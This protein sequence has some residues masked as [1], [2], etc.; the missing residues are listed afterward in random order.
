MVNVCDLSMILL[1]Q[2]YLLFASECLVGDV[3]R[4]EASH[5]VIV[6][7]HP[8]GRCSTRDIS[9]ANVRVV[10]S[11]VRDAHVDNYTVQLV[12][13]VAV[14][15][16][17][18]CSS[19]LGCLLFFFDVAASSSPRS[20]RIPLGRS[21]TFLLLLCSFFLNWVADSY[22]VREREIYISRQQFITAFQSP[23]CEYSLK[24]I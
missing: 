14:W 1:L 15:M 11:G 19:L 20:V 10:M 9:V 5:D 6:E 3:F 12:L 13:I 16:F 4:V 22:A 8:L 24:S 17:L 23:C 2:R 21:R 18:A 7:L